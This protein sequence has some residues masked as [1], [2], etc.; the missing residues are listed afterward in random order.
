MGESSKFK[1]VV[2]L[3]SSIDMKLPLHLSLLYDD[4]DRTSATHGFEVFISSSISL[5]IAVYNLIFFSEPPPSSISSQIY[6]SSLSE[7]LIGIFIL[8]LVRG[9]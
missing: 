8:L 1:T 6:S 9:G 3:L 7:R 4:S 5:G 2:G